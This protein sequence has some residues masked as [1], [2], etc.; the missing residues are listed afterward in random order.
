MVSSGGLL[1][2][3][4]RAMNGLHYAVARINAQS[5]LPTVRKK[6][7]I[8]SAKQRVPGILARFI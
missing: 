2:I 4:H 1:R 8:A 7:A 3:R 6:D 5:S